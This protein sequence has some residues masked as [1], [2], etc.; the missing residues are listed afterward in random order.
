MRATRRRG[1]HEPHDASDE[2]AFMARALEVLN[3]ALAGQME[4][5]TIQA[6]L[7]GYGFCEVGGGGVGG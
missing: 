7:S 6:F 2:E 3:L 1:A 5:R 4:A